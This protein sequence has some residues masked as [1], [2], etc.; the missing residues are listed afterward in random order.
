MQL[1]PNLV[2]N[3]IAE[4]VLAH[5][6]DALGGEVEIMRFA[7]S[8]VADTICAEWAGKVMYGSL[9][10]PAGTI[11]IMD[12]PPDRAGKPGD[13]FMIGVQTESAAQTDAVFAKLAEGGTVI[14]PLEKTFWSE[15][16]GMLTDKFG[17]KWMVNQRQTG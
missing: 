2:F 6:H 16:F 4:T 3:G 8:P 14:M 13:N 10:S 15:R 5:Y 1:T 12:A 17:T 7:D 9:R 11:S